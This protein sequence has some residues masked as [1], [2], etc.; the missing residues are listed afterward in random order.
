MPL[1]A[2]PKKAQLAWSEWMPRS[3]EGAAPLPDG[4]RMR[5]KVLPRQSAGARADVRP[6]GDRDRRRRLLR[7]QSRRDASTLAADRAVPDPIQGHA[8]HDRLQE[9]G[10]PS[11][12]SL[13]FDRF[14]SVALLPGAPDALLVH[15]ATEDQTGP[16][17]LLVADGDKVRSEFVAESQ[18][19]DAA[20]LLTNDVARVPA[21][22]GDGA[23]AGQDRPND[24]RASGGVTV[25][26]IGGLHAAG[27]RSS[28]QADVGRD[29]RRERAAARRVAGRPSIRADRVERGE[30]AHAHRDRRDVGGANAS[31]RSTWREMRFSQVGLLDPEWL[32]H[33]LTWTRGG[34]RRV[35]ARGRAAGDAAAVEGAVDSAERTRARI[36]G[37]AGGRSDV[38]GDGAFLTTELGA[39][40]T[41][42]D[43]AASGT[44]WQAHLNGQ[45]VH[46]FDNT[47]EH[48][49]TIYLDQGADTKVLAT[50]A[51]RF[52]AALA[53]GKYDALF[54]TDVER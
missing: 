22:A 37:R 9:R 4:F 33:Y 24:V 40:R 5:F 14:E 47:R 43:E 8:R 45:V 15:S 28:L 34:G 42:E 21:R 17:Y 23:R 26:G 20:T 2:W 35:R 38:R 19:L 11:R 12:T 48:H 3:R 50:I 30:H 51:E 18:P 32:A 54:T 16:L 25:S 53:T 44:G 1:P 27:R 7:L 29:D 31:C 13:R 52:D 10:T 49:V 39:T 36:S 41:P 6:V 46:L